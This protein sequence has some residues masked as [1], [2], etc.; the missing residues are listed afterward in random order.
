MKTKDFSSP[1]RLGPT[2]GHEVSA[3]KRRSL[4]CLRSWESVILVM[5]PLRRSHPGNSRRKSGGSVCRPRCGS[6]TSSAWGCQRHAGVTGEGHVPGSETLEP[7]AA[8]LCLLPA[9]QLSTRACPGAEVG[10]PLPEDK[11]NFLG[12]G[13]LESVGCCETVLLLLRGVNL[14]SPLSQTQSQGPQVPVGKLRLCW[15]L[16]LQ[17]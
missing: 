1:E 6:S 8:G 17:V 3:A 5:F 11:T 7:G 2:P 4:R 10:K 16:A 15:W 12:L 13:Q 14:S 9:G